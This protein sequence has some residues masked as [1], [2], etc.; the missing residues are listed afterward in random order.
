[1]PSFWI[2]TNGANSP[3]VGNDLNGYKI[4]QTT[5]GFELY[6]PNPNAQRLAKVDQT[7]L[8]VTFENVTIDGLTWDITV[9]TV[10]STTDAGSWV[11]PSQHAA[12]PEDVPPQSGE[13][14]AQVGGSMEEDAAAAA[15]QGKQ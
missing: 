6:P 13:F 1:M 10:P 4:K 5:D 12:R 2:I 7:S 8:P 11:T 9:D 15:G 14:T 3:V